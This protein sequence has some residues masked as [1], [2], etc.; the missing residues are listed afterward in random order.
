VYGSMEVSSNMMK[1]KEITK[2]GYWGRILRVNLSAGTVVEEEVDLHILRLV[3]G[4]AGLGAY[5][6]QRDMDGSIGP[7]DPGN[8][9]IFATGPFQATALPGSAKWTVCARSPLS[10]FYGEAAAGGNWGINLKRAGYDAIVI[11]GASDLP[12][13]LLV[14]DRHAE[15]RS[16]ADLWGKKTSVALRMIK[17]EVGGPRTSVALI[18]PAGEKLIRYACI[19]VDGH[20]VAG[21]TGMGA[22]MGSKKLKAICVV[23]SSPPGIQQP[24]ELR[25]LQKTLVPLI[26]E[27]T[28]RLHTSGT[29]GYMAIGESFGDVPTKNWQRGVWPEGNAKLGPSQYKKLLVSPVACAYCP[30]ACHRLVRV[31]QPTKYRMKGPGPEYE[32]LAMIGQNCLIDNL[33]AICKANEI[34][35]EYGLDTISA[36]SSVAFAMECFDRGFLTLA[37]TDGI[38]LEWGNADGMLSLLQTIADRKGLGDIL[39]EGVARGATTIGTETLEFAVTVK[40]VDLPGHSPRAFWAHALNYATG[41]RGA[42]HERG[43][44]LLPYFGTLIPELGVTRKAEQFTMENVDLLT[45]KYQ[46]WAAFWNS[47]VICRFMGLSF[48][49]MVE[50]LNAITGWGFDVEE[51]GRTAERILTLQ[52][53][54]NVKFGVSREHDVLPKRLYEPVNDGPYAGKTLPNIQRVLEAY[55]K[56]RGWDTNGVP[57]LETIQRLGIS[58]IL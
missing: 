53:L 37:D 12:V 26:Q 13:Y 32:T 41:V 42:C 33:A 57:T 50:A 25:T 2:C 45:A 28:K 24:S 44:L 3:I 18:G 22:V 1:D 10:N 47:L 58:D 23:G 34:C 14:H 40:G 54:V 43:A 5:Y 49:Q 35:N 51:A 48:T 8:L 39:A 6:L 27:R 16:A 15:I 21:R 11:S 55:Y 46:D 9:L 29:P 17:D 7:F 20:S 30:V 31:D 56:L 4:G 36:G 19:I 38:S 52:R